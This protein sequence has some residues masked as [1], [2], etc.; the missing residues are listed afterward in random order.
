MN[1]RSLLS[2]T[3]A[4]ALLAIGLVL[5]QAVPV[6]AQGAT[7]APIY[8]FYFDPYQV[9]MYRAVN[10]VPG[11]GWV[12]EGV[13]YYVSP[14]QLPYTVPLYGLFLWLP[15]DHFYTIDAASRDY[16][17]KTLGYEDQGVLGYVLPVDMDLPGTSPLYRWVRTHYGPPNG[18]HLYQ[19]HFYMT[20]AGP[21]ANYTAEG[22]ACRV[23]TQPLK[24]PQRLLELN[25]PLAGATLNVNDSPVISWKVWSNGG[26]IRLTYS[27]D[28]G[29][30]W[31]HIA[32]MVNN[33][34]FADVNKQ[35]FNYWKVP[36]AAVGKIKIKVAW[37]RGD[38]PAQQNPNV[39][40]PQPS[41]SV[42]PWATD[43]SGPITVVNPRL[44]L[45]HP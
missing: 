24:L 11:D 28:N 12:P 43:I 41:D 22:V 1:T 36:A 42:L 32:T 13:A 5:V 18:N 6:R 10:T 20:G 39:P 14:I 15:H 45:L 2:R 30:S 25:A 38:P 29:A 8:R 7:T 26:W 19:D 16:L 4:P 23:W 40:A 37:L 27:T 31:Q 3:F 21:V 17:I 33:G 44:R 9:H 34:S 35:S